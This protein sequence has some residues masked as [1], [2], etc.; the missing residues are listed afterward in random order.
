MYKIARSTTGYSSAAG[1][2]GTSNGNYREYLLYKL[3]IPSVTIEIG[4]HTLSGS[5]N[6][7]ML[8]LLSGTKLV[9]LKEAVW[10]KKEKITL[11]KLLA[12]RP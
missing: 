4:K 12:L 10:L 2:G 6:V 11:K 9:V 1:Y 7:N 3:K 5:K 8:L